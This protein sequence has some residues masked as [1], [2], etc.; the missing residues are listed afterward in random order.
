MLRTDRHAGRAAG[1]RSGPRPLS[2]GDFVLIL[3]GERHQYRNSSD[4]P[5]VFMCMAPKEYE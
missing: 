4:Q 5:L 3:P 1:G 2:Q